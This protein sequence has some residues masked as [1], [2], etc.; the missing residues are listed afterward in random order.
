MVG[1]KSL[2]QE[3]WQAAAEAYQKELLY[4]DREGSNRDHLIN[5]LDYEVKRNER[6]NWLIQPQ[7]SIRN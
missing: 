2:F 4:L 7:K 1:I 3:C 6:K 5:Q